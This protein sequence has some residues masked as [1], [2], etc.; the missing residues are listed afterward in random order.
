MPKTIV[1]RWDQGIGW[2]NGSLCSYITET[3]YYNQKEKKQIDNSGIINPQKVLKLNDWKAERKLG[4]EDI[5]R[6]A[7]VGELELLEPELIYESDDDDEDGKK[8]S[9]IGKMDAS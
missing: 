9:K 4:V 5:E 1:N 2:R 6:A 8:K 7:M 3:I